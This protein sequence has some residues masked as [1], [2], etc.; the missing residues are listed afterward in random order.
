[1]KFLHFFYHIPVPRVGIIILEDIQNNPWLYFVCANL[2]TKN[3]ILLHD[4]LLV[5]KTC[6]HKAQKNSV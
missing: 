5:D 6:E 2:H 3:F 4:L 1:M